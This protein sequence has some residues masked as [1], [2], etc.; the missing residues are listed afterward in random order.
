MH[1]FVCSAKIIQL[2]VQKITKYPVCEDRQN[3]LNEFD[4][5]RG[6]FAVVAFFSLD[7]LSY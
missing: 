1:S 4:F 5:S 2:M 6:I 3:V 7:I